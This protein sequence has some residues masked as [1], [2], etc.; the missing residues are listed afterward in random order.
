[1]GLYPA[2]AALGIGFGATPA[3]VDEICYQMS[4]SDST[5]AARQALARRGLDLGQKPTLRLTNQVS[6]RAAAQRN[7]WLQRVLAD[8]PTPG[9]M[10]GKRV[11]IATD[12]GRLRLR[13]PKPGRRRATGHHGFDA[14]WR[15]P[16][17][18]VIYVLDDDGKV[19]RTFRP[20][21][22]ATLDDA[23]AISDMLVGYLASLGAHEARALVILGDGARWIWDRAADLVERVGIEATRVTEVVDWSHA[24]AVLHA[25]A[26]IPAKWPVWRRKLWEQD[27]R[28]LLHAGNID[29]L[30]SM[31]DALAVGRR[32]KEVRKHKGYF[33]GN[34]KRM[35]YA[36]FEAAKLPTG[37]GA[38][39]SA[40]RQVVNL[41]M[42][43]AG[44][45]WDERN[46]QGMLL[47]RSYLKAGRFD[48]L[49]HWSFAVAVPWWR[50]DREIRAAA[51][52]PIAEV[53]VA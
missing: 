3:V 1:V 13:I 17:H 36:T 2:L 40:L 29:A 9:T 5:Q 42:K 20:I 18:L 10:A 28:D 8:P 33:T 4:A 43:G 53:N 14:P 12:G 48:D 39:E 24:A 16:K 23:D 21:Y 27:A 25:I 37:S 7:E 19:D 35:Q 50:P 31:I 45:F 11:A 49:L 41:R 47:L 15:E 44:K 52:S 22:D 32:A 30:A 26:D 46:A 34:A 38:V 51:S 6:R